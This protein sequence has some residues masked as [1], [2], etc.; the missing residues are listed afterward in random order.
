[1]RLAVTAAQNASP[2]APILLRGELAGAVAEAGDMGY[3]GIE[4][5]VP[6]IWEFDAASLAASCKSANVG[7][8]ALVTG[9]L[10]VRK[11]LNLSDDK[12]EIVRKAVE[13]LMLF[14]DA[15]AE[16]EC[17]IVAGWVRGRVGD[18]D[19]G[20]V[21]ARQAESLRKVG[22]YAR[23]KGV[24]V[25]IEVINRYELDSLTTA[26]EAI[27]FIRQ[28]RLENTYIHLDTFH[29]NIDEYSPGKAIRQC[30]SL[31]GYMHLA[32]NTRHYPGYGR[33]DFDE[34][35]A[36]LKEVG[37]DGFV[38]VECL[39]V[40]SGPEAAKRA[41]EFLTYRYLFPRHRV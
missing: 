37:Y 40:P 32:E 3:E 29:M 9:Q 10:F 36:A 30:G 12:P 25:Y 1:M 11:G 7:V 8:S 18:R 35:F 15:A 16:L 13:G 17:G 14:V 19:R 27:A 21:M 34:V 39:P 5:H 28:N 24:P 2:M 33:L 4:I 20:A 6:D 22:E 38:S 26:Q 23:E 31:L 41:H